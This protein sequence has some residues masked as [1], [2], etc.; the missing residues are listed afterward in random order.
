MGDLQK[1]PTCGTP[2]P[3]GA[4]D[5]ICPRCALGGALDA[6]SAAEP[7]TDRC[8]AWQALATTTTPRAFGDY[9]L[10]E[11]IGRGGMG[12][13]FK[14]RQLA[15]DRL[16]AVKLLLAGAYSSES[17]LQRFRLEAAAAARLQ[18]PN[19]V[20]I[21]DYGECDGQPYYVM[22][23]V[24]GRNLAQVCDGRPLNPS[25]AATI[26]REL[27]D[28]LHQAHRLGILHRDL[29]PSNVLLDDRDRPHI[30]D[31]G[32]ARRLNSDSGVTVTG[33]IMG[34]P[35][36][37][38]PE[39]VSGRISEVGVRSDVY[40]LG[41][42]LYH[43]LT[44]RA[45]INAATPTETLRLVLE[46]DPPWPRLLNPTVPRELE[47]ICLKSLAKEP[48]RRYATASE[49]GDDLQRFLNRR[50]IR[51]R[52]PS[53]VYRT[54]KF[55]QRYRTGVAA[56][57]AIIVALG[58]GL[59]L[60]LLGYQRAVEQ[61][62]ATNAARA[63]A[64]E[65][66][67]FIMRELHPQLQALGRRKAMIASA[68]TAV[69][70]FEQL[71]PDLR[72]RE[73]TRAHATALDLL[74][75]AYGITWSR[76][77]SEDPVAV[78]PVLKQATV[79]WRQL[80]D[81][82]PN[83]AHAAAAALEDEIVSSVSDPD[84]PASHKLEIGR[85]GLEVFRKLE[86]RFPENEHV[87]TGMGRLL[88]S[89]AAK[90]GG[91]V[92]DAQAAV[93][94]GREAVTRAERLLA[95]RPA[96]S[97]LRSDRV[98]A[99]D[100]LARAL[101]DNDE[102]EAATHVLEEALSRVETFLSEDATNLQTLELASTVSMQLMWL[103]GGAQRNAAE[104]VRVARRY[105]AT[106]IA[107]DPDD[108]EWRYRDTMALFME[109]VA[110]FEDRHFAEAMRSAGQTLERW[111]SLAS[112]VSDVAEFYSGVTLSYF[113]ECAV[114][115]G[116]P[117]HATGILHR[118]QDEFPP[119]VNAADSAHE[120]ARRRFYYLYWQDVIVLRLG[121][122][123]EA[124]RLSREMLAEAGRCSDDAPETPLLPPAYRTG[125]Q[126]S[127]GYSLLHQGRVAEVV[128]VVDEAVA[129]LRTLDSMAPFDEFSPPLRRSA[130]G[131]LARALQETGDTR[132]VIDLLE[133][134]YARMDAAVNEGTLLSPRM[135]LV[136]CAWQLAQA[137]DPQDPAQAE[138]RH[139]VLTRALELL[140]DPGAAA[141][142]TPKEQELRPQVSAAL[143]AS[144]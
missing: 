108:P 74:V 30:T 4:P 117:A 16:V 88:R 89:L 23:L 132:R 103:S 118:L 25:R 120:R 121:N 142:L 111:S 41:G 47:I 100:A 95:K 42:I 94:L 14:A 131:I 73:T 107:L 129:R 51:A 113:A 83:D 66:V 33:Q 20:P 80:A 34:S 1:C 72:D 92:R 79:L 67:N 7:T 43:L 115:A 27:A 17:M 63:R 141:R 75:Q 12:V 40:G 68:Q 134:A 35:G 2:I 55:V 24:P 29:K 99:S 96:D 77:L 38:S 78:R 10:L 37:A 15:L 90:M 52:P 86:Q 19:I 61:Q 110:W 135:E 133:W 93:D 143:H 70:Y 127:L 119:W 5:G 71:P 64:Q 91:R 137:L 28:A 65:M 57:A 39:Q 126:I 125:A 84:V 60:A 13:V 123:T 116:Q 44:G 81:S 59:T 101:F 36:Y 49:V 53:I 8:D 130:A 97:Q 106:L 48:A 105:L 138:R 21:H 9:E 87:Q 56:V 22:D 144:D 85:R 128:P 104:R 140:D 46:S 54:R 122:W 124:E 18:H 26:L 102:K 58:A 6:A 112:Q 11:E 69:R 114:A 76:T 82:D 109:S 31:F 32:L 98:W 45:P 62:H 139:E 136:Q 50:P 3:D